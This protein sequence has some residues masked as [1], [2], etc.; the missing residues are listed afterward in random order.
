MRVNLKLRINSIEKLKKPSKVEL[1]LWVKE[2]LRHIELRENV[3]LD[4]V[5]RPPDALREEEGDEE[6]EDVQNDENGGLEEEDNL[7][8]QEEIEYHYL[9]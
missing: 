7:V 1:L 5:F 2:A 4:T 6:N 8:F 9:H 3:F